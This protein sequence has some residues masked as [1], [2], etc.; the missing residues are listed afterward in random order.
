MQKTH[1]AYF[2]E[3]ETIPL[4]FL[5]ITTGNGWRRVEADINKF[6]MKKYRMSMRIPVPQLDSFKCKA[7][8]STYFFQ[9][10]TNYV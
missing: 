1:R 5:Y 8:H 10:A 3:S 6:V 2:E 9:K 7:R 4:P